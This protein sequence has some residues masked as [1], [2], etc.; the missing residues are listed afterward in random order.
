LD[1]TIR[2]KL[3]DLEQSK[4]IKIIHAC[5]SGSRAWGFASSDSNHRVRFLYTHPVEWYISIF[6]KKDHIDHATEDSINMTGWDI[7][8]A[9]KLMRKSNT[10]LNEWLT[11]P[12]VYKTDK[13]KARKLVDF[14]EMNFNPA[15][16]CH[17]YLSIARQNLASYKHDKI[18]TKSYLI[19]LRSILCSMWVSKYETQPPVRLEVLIEKFY[20]PESDGKLNLYIEEMIS[21]KKNTQ[22]KDKTKRSAIFEN[23]AKLCMKNIEV[24]VPGDVP[25]QPAED[26][27]TLLQSIILY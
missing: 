5:E 4:N 1:K 22:E 7:R 18:R 9:M 10:R 17:H 26:F 20:N 23:Y 13:K 11:S 8:K 27:D 6:K 19:A 21:R 24:N 3:H 15:T 14:S 12:V 16:S 25:P 2:Q